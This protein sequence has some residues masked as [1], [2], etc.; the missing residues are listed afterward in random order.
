MYFLHFLGSKKG[1]VVNGVIANNQSQRKK[2][3][4]G[5]EFVMLESGIINSFKY[6]LNQ[7]YVIRSSFT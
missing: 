5:E 1:L 4:E 7:Q 3:F 6:H 2:V